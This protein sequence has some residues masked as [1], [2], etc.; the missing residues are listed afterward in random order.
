MALRLAEQYIEA[1]SQLAKETNTILLPEKTGD[2]GSMVAQA[3]SV[4][5]TIQNQMPADEAKD[6]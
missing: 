1:F 2:M 4:F 5:K 6:S 3:L